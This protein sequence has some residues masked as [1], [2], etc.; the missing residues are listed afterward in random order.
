[1]T[2]KTSK[3]RGQLQAVYK[4]IKKRIKSAE[5]KKVDVQLR[6]YV[7]AAAVFLAFAEI[8]NYV[9]DVFSSFSNCIR[10]NVTK[11]SKLP[12]NVR[13]HLFLQKSNA[14]AIFGNFITSNSEKDLFR[15][16]SSALSSHAG[17]YIDDAVEI[18]AFSGKDL[19]TTI[20]YPSEKNLEKLFFR[21]G[22]DKIFMVLSKILREDAKAL[23]ESIS[24]LRTQ[25]AHTGTLPGISAKDVKARLASAERFVG[26]MDRVMYQVTTSHYKAAE[27]NAHLC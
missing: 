12:G 22:V 10:A 8:E 20:K 21:I 27:W 7:I 17:S 1:M 23:L 11:G 4:D 16:F 25:L 3:A 24:S 9:G 2:Y 14:P 5:N 13:P 18:K 6:E 26:A 19:Y 15:S